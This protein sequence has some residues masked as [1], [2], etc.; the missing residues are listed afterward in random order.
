MKA[1][2]CFELLVVAPLRTFAKR[3]AQLPKHCGFIGEVGLLRGDKVPVVV[4]V[5]EVVLVALEV[6]LAVAV[7]VAE[8]RR[9]TAKGA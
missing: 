5:E 9:A 8:P 3:F 2:H 6:A 4:A 1:V 7:V